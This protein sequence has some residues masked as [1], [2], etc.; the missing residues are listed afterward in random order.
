MPGRCFEA[1]TIRDALL[2]LSGRLSTRQ[3]GPPVPVAPDDGAQIVVSMDTRDA[4]GRHTGK[5]VPLGEEEF[6]RSIYVQVR[7]SMPLGMLEPFDAPV[8]RP[9]FQQR[10]A[11]TAAAQ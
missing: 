4:A 5:V 2:A 6:R 1:E 11:S 7:R 8:M 10:A 3:Y 9:N